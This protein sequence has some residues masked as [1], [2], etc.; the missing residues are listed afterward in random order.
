MRFFLLLS[1]LSVIL[2]LSAKRNG[3]VTAM[4]RTIETAFCVR[5]GTISGFCAAIAAAR[6]GVKTVL[7][8]KDGDEAG[9]RTDGSGIAEEIALRA[10]GAHAS[11]ADIMAE[12]ADGEENLTVI[13]ADAVNLTIENRRITSM[14]GGGVTVRADLF[15][16]CTKAAA[17]VPPAYRITETAAPGDTAALGG[18]GEDGAVFGVSCRYLLSD[19]ADNLFL[20][21]SS[22]ALGQAAGTAAAIAVKYGTTPAGVAADHIAELQETLQYDDCFL[23]YCRRAVSEAALTAALECDDTLSGDILNLRTGI[24]RSHRIYGEGDQGFTMAQGASIEYHMD[25]PQE[26]SRT[27]IVFDADAAGTDGMP[28]ALSKVYA[29]EIETE[30]GWE[31][32]LF[33]NE[34]TRRVITAAI[35]RPLTGIRLT[36]METWGAEGVHL[37][38]FDFE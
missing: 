21:D 22:A 8:A 15:A 13:F 12:M 25:T 31:G 19:T 29:L 16:D 26:V 4:E 37:L 34:N 3:E 1:G 32:I 2:I 20:A 33:E 38:S 24:D 10:G 9:E 28:P 27:R 17:S 11:P 23:P 36:V 14:S 7:F 5:G 18:E 6:H 30:K 35:C